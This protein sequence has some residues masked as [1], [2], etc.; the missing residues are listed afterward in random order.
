MALGLTK[1]TKNELISNCSLPCCYSLWQY[2]GATMCFAAIKHPSY[3]NGIENFFTQTLWFPPTNYVAKLSGYAGDFFIMNR[4]HSEEF[5][6]VGSGGLTLAIPNDEDATVVFPSIG[7]GF[8]FDSYN[9]PKSRTGSIAFKFQQL[10]ENSNLKFY[11]SVDNLSI[12][13]ANKIWIETSHTRNGDFVAVEVNT[14]LL[15]DPKAEAVTLKVH[16]LLPDFSLGLQMPGR[17]YSSLSFSS[18]FATV[19]DSNQCFETVHSIY[20]VSP[21]IE[22]FGSLQV[23][24]NKPYYGSVVSIFKYLYTL[25]GYYILFPSVSGVMQN[26]GYK[27]EFGEEIFETYLNI[28]FR[29]DVY[30]FFDGNIF[31][32]HCSASSYEQTYGGP[33]AYSSMYRNRVLG[34]GTITI[35][36]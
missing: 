20:G 33:S 28:D 19:T 22:S 32:F 35:T 30:Q 4:A 23:S 5:G 6:T 11:Y 8:W 18:M 13:D 7:E 29:E 15:G 21:G 36:T 31:Y 3:G 16:F 9:V 34:T 1:N 10:T 25:Y 26:T 12:N 2:T 24:C 14:I 17:Q 27:N